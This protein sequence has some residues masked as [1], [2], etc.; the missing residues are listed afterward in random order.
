MK[1]SLQKIL[2]NDWPALALA[3]AIPIIWIIAVVFPHI[4]SGAEFNSMIAVIVSTLC[5][6]LLIA[7]ILS[8]RAI[9]NSGAV[10]EGRVVAV[11]I[12]KDRGRFEYEYEV[13]GAKVFTWRAVHKSKH[14]LGFR[15]G[16]SVTVAYDPANP[17][18][19]IVRE[20]FSMANKQ[21]A[22]QD[23]TSNGG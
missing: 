3:V 8:I 22:Q 18:R 21:E 23:A 14:V 19:S 6:I 15:P 10:T 12:V 2:W 11:R 16:D 13:E 7:R 20:L 4:R 9:W 5:I 1:L 17:K